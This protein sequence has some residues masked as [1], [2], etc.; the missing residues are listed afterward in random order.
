[1]FLLITDDEAEQVEQR[2]VAQTCGGWVDEV[3]G[4]RVQGSSLSHRS[5]FPNAAAHRRISLEQQEVVH[6]GTFPHTASITRVITLTNRKQISTSHWCKSRYGADT[7][8]QYGDIPSR[9][10]WGS[11]TACLQNA[12]DIGG[13]ALQGTEAI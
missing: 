8:S 1:M 9:A 3:I 5:F 2:R 12:R 6:H 13:Q 4:H 7:E 10:E 11:L